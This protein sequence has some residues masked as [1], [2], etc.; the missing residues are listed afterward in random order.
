MQKPVLI[1]RLHYLTRNSD[2][3]FANSNVAVIVEGHILHYHI[4]ENVHGSLKVGRFDFQS[5]N[6]A[7]VVNCGGFSEVDGQDSAIFIFLDHNWLLGTVLEHWRFV[8][9]Q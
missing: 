2:V 6:A 9:Y 4:L 3:D 5:G 1:I 7:R 8:I